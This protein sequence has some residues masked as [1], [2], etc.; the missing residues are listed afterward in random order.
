MKKVWQKE[1]QNVTM[2]TASLTTHSREMAAAIQRAKIYVRR[3]GDKVQSI[4]CPSGG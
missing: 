4:A 2:V 1:L 3:M